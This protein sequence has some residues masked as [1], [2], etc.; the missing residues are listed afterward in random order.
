MKKNRIVL[1]SVLSGTV[2][3]ICGTFF[4]GAKYAINYALNP[5]PKE[6]VTF[7]ESDSWLVKES[8][9]VETQSFDGLNLKAY[10]ATSAKPS[11]KY[12]IFMHGYRDTPVRMGDYALHFYEKG[13]NVIVPGQR[14]HGWSEGDYI[15]MGI[16]ACRDVVKWINLILEQDKD[17]QIMLYGVS[18]GAATVMNTTGKQLPQNVKCAI[19]DCGYSSA[20]DQFKYRISTEIHLP[21]FPVLNIT[22]HIAKK[23]YGFNFRDVAPKNEIH[24]SNTPMLFIHG[25]ADT[26]VP[27]YMQDIVFNAAIC[28]KEKLV[29]PGAVHA[30]SVYTEP[31]LYW[32]TVDRFVAKYIK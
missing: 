18:M 29:I 15:D 28:E 3:L 24:N 17:A 9:I 22:E 31:E 7:T 8:R 1:I 30:K 5:I 27:F 4:G 14:G 19:E 13:W 12:G 21:A 2:L 23:R 11:H 20:W 32:S 26:Y 25:T 6:Q 10:L 16:F